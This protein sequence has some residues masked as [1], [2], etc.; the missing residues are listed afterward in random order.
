MKI[1]ISADMEGASGIVHEAPTEPGARE[2]DRACALMLGDVN[3]AIEG[4]LAGGA[5]RILVNDSHWNMRNLRI[6][7]LHPAAELISGS[8][9][10]WS[11]VEGIDLGWDAAFFVG[12]HAMAGTAQATIDHTYTDAIA[13]VTLNGQAVGELGLNAAAAGNF[14]VPVVFVSGDQS[15]AAEAKALFKE[16][17]VA[18]EVKRA[19][20]RTAAHCLP[21]PEARR[22]IREGAEHA[23]KLKG[24]P[25]QLSKPIH[26]E[27]ELVKASHADQ[28]ALTPGVT[29]VDGRTL[30]FSHREYME[31]YRVWRTIYNLAGSD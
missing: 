25:W 13:R 4:A 27:V 14:A 23:M 7:D 29:R 17:I 26:L 18:V 15:L 2:Y 10:P 31:V 16:D 19:V 22:R 21:L 20:S 1:Y 12:Y 8:P 9:K 11:M 24:K 6:E 30:R 3:A 5:T 28:A